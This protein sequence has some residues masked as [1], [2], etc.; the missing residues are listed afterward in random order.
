MVGF[1]LRRFNEIVKRMNKYKNHT[2]VKR[3]EKKSQINHTT[4]FSQGIREETYVGFPYSMPM[5]IRYIIDR[6]RG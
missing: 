3:K 2:H 4:S 5:N 1:Y 6:F